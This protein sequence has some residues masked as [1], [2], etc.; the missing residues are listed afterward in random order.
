MPWLRFDDQFNNHPKILQAGFVAAALHMR[1]IIYCGQYLTDGFVPASVP[2]TLINLGQGKALFVGDMDYLERAESKLTVVLNWELV[3]RLVEVGLWAEVEGGWQIHDYLEWNPSGEETKLRRAGAKEAKVKAGRLGGLAKAAAAKQNPSSGLAE[4]QQNPSSAEAETK[5]APDP[6]PSPQNDPGLEKGRPVPTKTG[7]RGAEKTKQ[8]Q[9]PNINPSRTLAE[10]KQT[11]SR[12]P[13]KS[14]AN[15]SPDPDPDPDPDRVRDRC[16]STLRVIG[17]DRSEDIKIVVA[18]YQNHHPRS[19]PKLNSKSKEWRAIRARLEEG[20]T[21]QDLCDAI[22][23]CHRSPWH[24]GENDRNKK[25]D[26]L[27]LITRDGSKVQQ[28]M[29]IP[30]TNATAGYST[31]SIQTAQAALA[32]A[33]EEES[34]G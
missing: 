9:D 17:A 2:D 14:V 10:S 22:D 3:E 26:S 23:G 32:W 4:S 24:Q 8:K 1:A 29:E 25:Y 31:K 15:P 18:H 16:S 33:T 19:H 28:F 27:E 5:Q 34:N 6:E 13:S 30:T 21:V 11:S 12:T 20:W 7:R